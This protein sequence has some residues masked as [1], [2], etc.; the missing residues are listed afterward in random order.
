MGRQRP[1]TA[2]MQLT[3]TTTL[4]TRFRRNVPR[5]TSD[6]VWLVDDKATI[7]I[8]PEMHQMVGKP[9]SYAIS[10]QSIIGAIQ[11]EYAALSIKQ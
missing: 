4:S 6:G 1:L 10:V 5:P 8:A 7:F 11:I 9:R 3:R 2:T